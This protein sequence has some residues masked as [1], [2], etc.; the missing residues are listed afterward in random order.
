LVSVAH[1]PQRYCEKCFP[2]RAAKLRKARRALKAAEGKHVS[3]VADKSAPE[4]RAFESFEEAEAWAQEKKAAGCRV[5][6]RWDG[7]CYRAMAVVQEAKTMKRMP[8]I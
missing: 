5:S 1:R 8:R 3:E 4:M 6:I 7:D 2:G